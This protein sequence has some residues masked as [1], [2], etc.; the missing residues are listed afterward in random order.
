MEK[1]RQVEAELQPPPKP[2]PVYTSKDI[3]PP[4]PAPRAP[5]Y[6]PPSQQ[7][8][9]RAQTEQIFSYLPDLARVVGTK[10]RTGQYD[11]NDLLYL[12]NRL[13]WLSKS[14]GLDRRHIGQLWA[15]GLSEAQSP[16]RY[17]S[18]RPTMGPARDPF[19]MAMEELADSLDFEWEPPKPTLVQKVIGQVGGGVRWWW[20][21]TLWK[22]I[23]DN[24]HAQAILNN[25][26]VRDALKASAIGVGLPLVASGG[27]WASMAGLALL[28]AGGAPEAATQMALAPQLLPGLGR[29]G[30][31]EAAETLLG[32]QSLKAVAEAETERAANITKWVQE[33]A[34]LA[35]KEAPTAAE[36]ARI[37]YLGERVLSELDLAPT[38]EDLGRPVVMGGKAGTLVGLQQNVPIV[39][40][41]G[42]QGKALPPEALG[43][44]KPVLEW[45]DANA[46]PTNIKTGTWAALSADQPGMT[47][48]QVSEA[49]KRLVADLEAAG[50]KPVLGTGKFEGVEAPS[51]LV[52]GMDGRAAA[53]FGKR[54]GQNYV[55]TNEGLVNVQTGVTTLADLEKTEFGSRL[56]DNY[57]EIPIGGKKIRFSV[58]L[59]NEEKL[60]E[61][62]RVLGRRGSRVGAGG[63][64][65]VVGLS[66]ED[67]YIL[68]PL[69]GAEGSEFK[70]AKSA[71]EPFW[72]PSGMAPEEVGLSRVEREAAA[73]AA[74]RPTTVSLATVA[75]DEGRTITLAANRI[76]RAGPGF[77]TT[78]A[79]EAAGLRAGQ[80]V[81][82]ARPLVVTPGG[83]LGEPVG[84]VSLHG[85]NSS[86]GQLIMEGGLRSGKTGFV[87]TTEDQTTAATHA[88][89]TVRELGGT[90]TVVYTET[91]A[92]PNLI[93]ADEAFAIQ[94][95][96][97]L[98][99][100][101]VWQPRLAEELRNRGIDGI[102]LN[103]LGF[104]KAGDVAWA[105]PSLVRPVLGAPTTGSYEDLIEVAK[106]VMRGDAHVFV[107]NPIA[108]GAGAGPYSPTLTAL[109]RQV[110]NNAF[111]RDQLLLSVSNAAKTVT[112]PEGVAGK[113]YNAARRPFN[114]SIGKYTRPAFIA[115]YAHREI[116]QTQFAIKMLFLQKAIQEGLGQRYYNLLLK[117]PTGKIFLD[118]YKGTMPTN[119]A[120]ADAVGRFVHMVE[121]VDDYK[122]P[123]TWRELFEVWQTGLDADFTLMTDMGYPGNLLEAAYIPHMDYE[124]SPSFLDNFFRDRPIG[125]VGGG[126][127]R[128]GLTRE[129]KYRGIEDWAEFLAEHGRQPEYDPFKLYARRL[130]ATA[131]LRTNQVYLQGVIG[132]YGKP[133]PK[134]KTP[135]L[136]WQEIMPGATPPLGTALKGIR[137][138]RWQVPDEVAAEARNLMNPGTEGSVAR[139]AEEVLD[140]FRGT[141]LSA[142]LS[143]WTIQGYALAAADPV[144]FLSTFAQKAQLS[145][146]EEGF[147]TELVNNIDAYTQF[148]RAGG[149]LYISAADIVKGFGTKRLVE[150]IPGISWLNQIGYGR[151]LPMMKVQ[152]WQSMT[153]ML[154]DLQQEKGLFQWFIK[155]LPGPVQTALKK[156]GGVEGKTVEELAQASAD[157][158]N[159]VGGGINWAN[160]MTRPTLAGK[161]IILT[162]GWVRAN[163]GR[164]INATKV[165]DPRGVLARRWLFQALAQTALISE[166][167]SIALS[168][169]HA[170]LDPRDVDFLDIQVPG[171]SV[172]ILPGKTYIRTVARLIG[173]KPWDNSVEGRVQEALRFGE[174]RFGQ[175]LRMGLDIEAG[176]DFMGRKIDNRALYLLRSVLPLAGQ[177]AVDMFYDPTQRGP[178]PTTAQFLGLNFIPTHPVEARD[179]FIKSLGLVDPLSGE[180]VESYFDMSEAQRKQFDEEHGEY[181]QA[182]REWQSL[183]QRPSDELNKARAKTTAKIAALGK[184]YLGQTLTPEEVG[185]LGGGEDYRRIANDRTL[186]VKMLTGMETEY[187]LSTKGLLTPAEDE[188]QSTVNKVV[189]GYYEKVVEPSIQGGVID[190]DIFYDLEGRYR[191][192]VREAFGDEGI[193]V[194][195]Q[196]LA[197]HTTDDP[198]AAAYH[199]DARE[200]GDYYRY[201]R[202][203]W[204]QANAERFGIDWAAAGQYGSFNSYK[205]AAIIA[206]RDE[207]KGKPLNP[208]IGMYRSSPRGDTIYEQFG[209]RPGQPL[210]DEQAG[211][212]AQE[213]VRLNTRK[214]QDALTYNTEN[215][216]I[217]HP[218]ILCDL[219]YWNQID[220]TERVRP[221]LSLCH[222]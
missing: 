25:P 123:A 212:V 126:G 176:Q 28:Q 148:A 34:E 98:P 10:L 75:T 97:G 221:Y 214:Y 154:I 168:G 23:L 79:S 8:F 36:Q 222:R 117:D 172:P 175:F 42:E 163:M 49:T 57:T 135:L 89:A 201:R 130:L 167:L 200:W 181:T 37:N 92:S 76:V 152:M 64:F 192:A 133:I 153:Q 165:G 187:Y 11:Q 72:T 146:T 40:L 128:L 101:D 63:T 218:N 189:R 180:P 50:Y 73:A 144:R 198:V 51:V 197:L 13:D 169:K 26:S 179:T 174:G 106:G 160:S 16:G 183:H 81:E 150:R 129:R 88:K 178:I 151:W 140:V 22:A 195:D 74:G 43:A 171:G 69:G 127:G 17:T 210:T 5:T 143:P 70:M 44:T 109:L 145:L 1:Y 219:T 39:R 84:K 100:T 6:T 82:N 111:D 95:E 196:E 87:F 77:G 159:N 158:V 53:T 19:D 68:R 21:R 149:T 105:N 112:M 120:R 31:K 66:D 110:S 65:Q 185:L 33:A 204:T 177:A 139:A 134:G 114:P 156:L 56:A 182:V 99:R 194:L 61:T 3:I 96:L 208:A 48:K 121:H 90:P 215:W 14:T 7:D 190:S 2:G 216:L 207:L 4:E 186:Y 147:I 141:L 45:A 91:P 119:P 155:E 142:D 166:A 38:T 118:L 107:L 184:A 15:I 164:I 60:P 157:I 32:R 131:N 62:V 35:S 191:A 55:F 41:L 9:E 113:L 193:A 116:E 125:G 80:A 67:T 205:V 24:P 102:D 132:A 52:P 220:P 94:K 217:E 209:I 138:G 71:T 199:A 47:P 104:H 12:D 206:T 137:V 170:T 115:A 83:L 136:G 20:D 93:S 188:E 29:V 78:M 59:T 124:P 211:E 203:L 54:Y 58:P 86:A 46:V 213:L 30:L 202:S 103:G 173:G 27:F 108:G 85:T 162:E 18:G 161:A 122:V